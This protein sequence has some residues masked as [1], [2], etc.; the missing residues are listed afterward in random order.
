VA[1]SCAGCG[2]SIEERH[3]SAR[4]CSDTCRQRGSRKQRQA[5]P[6]AAPE[7]ASEPELVAAVRRELETVDRLGSVLGQ[8]AL[9]LARQLASPFDTGSARAAV[10]RELR[11]TMAALLADA[12]AAADKLDELE[13]RRRLKAAGA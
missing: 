5:G 2:E 11:A 8:Q 4:Y 10:S 13:E 1:R 7:P 6:A 3:P 9:E 12:P